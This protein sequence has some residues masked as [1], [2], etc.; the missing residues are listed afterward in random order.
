MRKT[1]V[2]LGSLLFASSSAVAQ[3][4]VVIT[5]D[6]VP[7]KVVSYADLNLGS[8]AGQDRLVHRIRSAAEDICLE[9]NKEQVK[10]ETARRHCYSAA[11]KSGFNQMN[12]AIAAKAGGSTLASATLTIVGR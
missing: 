2:L 7:F 11:L 4:P 8:K 10:F 9:S 12:S 3:P 5:G 6:T 1:V